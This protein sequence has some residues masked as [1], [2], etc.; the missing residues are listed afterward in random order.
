[1]VV[2]GSEKIKKRMLKRQPVAFL[3]NGS[4]EIKKHTLKHQPV[5]IGLSM[6]LRK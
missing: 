3:V 2:A 6:G 5:A 1:M 4:E